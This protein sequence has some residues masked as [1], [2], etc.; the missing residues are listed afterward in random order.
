[1]E[2]QQFRT[3][4][5]DSRKSSAARA[6]GSQIDVFLTAT[7]PTRK[8]TPDQGLELSG[9]IKKVYLGEGVCSGA[10]AGEMQKMSCNFPGR[11]LRNLIPLKR[12]KDI[13]ETGSLRKKHSS[14]S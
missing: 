1:M 8:S 6:N 11:R 2:P 12:G 10:R 13:R 14:N 9:A 7:L 4:K 5:N 3:G